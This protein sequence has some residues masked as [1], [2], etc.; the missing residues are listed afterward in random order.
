MS[1][2]WLPTAPLCSILL[3]PCPVRGVRLVC[4]FAQTEETPRSSLRN[5]DTPSPFYGCLAH[6]PPVE[7]IQQPKFYARLN[8]GCS[9]SKTDVTNGPHGSTCQQYILSPTPVSIHFPGTRVPEG[10]SASPNLPL[11]ATFIGPAPGYEKGQG[12][13]NELTTP[14]HWRRKRSSSRLST[15]RDSFYFWEAVPL[16]HFRQGGA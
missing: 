16:W 4:K 7:G 14:S 2:L 12:A 10:F 13:T 15:E 3:T 6:P 1:S 9:I 11:A 8:L 5:F